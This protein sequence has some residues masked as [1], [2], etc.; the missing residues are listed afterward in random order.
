MPTVAKE[1]NV[2][3][4]NTP[5]GS[6]TNQQMKEKL[7]LRKNDC[8]KMED[9]NTTEEKIIKNFSPEESEFA[10]NHDVAKKDKGQTLKQKANQLMSSSS[11]NNFRVPDDSTSSEVSQEEGRPAAKTAS[12]RNKVRIQMDVTDDLDFTHSSD[13]T[14]EDVKLPTSTCRE[15]VLLLEQLTVDHAGSV[16]L[17]KI[18]NMLLKYEQIIEH[19]KNRYAAVSREVRKLESEK[20]KSK[21]LAEE[22]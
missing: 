8:L 2:D 11:G 14:S 19:E 15:A 7:I 21:L 22:T 1:E 16:I 3:K 20:E 13:T 18:Q 6:I 5:P 17:L 4:L 10:L 12:E 9:E